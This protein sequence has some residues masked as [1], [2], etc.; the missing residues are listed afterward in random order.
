M[1]VGAF[2]FLSIVCFLIIEPLFAIVDTAKPK[3]GA[4][5]CCK[6]TGSK[7]SSKEENK[8]CNP[9]MGCS[10]CNLFIIAKP[11]SYLHSVIIAKR[12]IIIRN[13]NRI[14]QHLSECWHPPNAIV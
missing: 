1:K 11:V 6:K 5:K 13:D 8:D 4:T 14:V 10:S 3:C 12:K 2:I 9:F 7:K